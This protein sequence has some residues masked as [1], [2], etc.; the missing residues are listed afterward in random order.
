MP[1]NKLWTSHRMILPEAREVIVNQCR[2]CR[3]FATI[4]GAREKRQGCVAGVRRYRTLSVRVPAV[5]HVMELMRSEGKE[6][7]NRILKK[8]NPGAQACE[9]WLPRQENILH[10]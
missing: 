10:V 3:F 8:G 4:Q 9:M 1:D 6:G 2:D 5:I 7:L